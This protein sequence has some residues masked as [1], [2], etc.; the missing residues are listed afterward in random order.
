MFI[1]SCKVTQDSHKRCSTT[2]RTSPAHQV[3]SQGCQTNNKPEYTSIAS[4]HQRQS[5][6]PISDRDAIEKY[7]QRRGIPNNRTQIPMYTVLR[8]QINLL[9][10]LG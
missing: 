8:R 5:I 3:S 7:S 4:R 2:T 1:K 9:E 6:G 10:E